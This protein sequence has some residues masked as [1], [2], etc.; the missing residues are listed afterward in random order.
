MHIELID[1]LLRALP[2]LLIGFP[3]ERPGGLLLSVIIAMISIILGFIIALGMGIVSTSRWVLLRWLAALYVNLGRALPL[4]FLLLFVHQF[5]GGRRFN[6]NFNPTE[7][8]II[9]LTV[10]ASVYFTEIIRVGWLSVPQTQIQSATL[11]GAGQLRLIRL[12]LNYTIHRFAPALVNQVITIFKDTSVIS[13]LAVTE[14]TFVSRAILSSNLQNSQYAVQ[15]Y[16]FVGL[17]YASVALLISQVA[18][19]KSGHNR[20]KQHYVTRLL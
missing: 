13:V 6:L 15:L 10:Y 9:A 2:N 12:R 1:F 14:L 18:T 11:L 19:L 17:L 5:I 20:L 3:Q 8:A 7:S 16:V 4:L